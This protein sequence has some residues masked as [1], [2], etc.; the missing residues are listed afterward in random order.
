MDGH[1][2]RQTLALLNSPLMLDRRRRTPLKW[3]SESCRIRAAAFSLKSSSVCQHLFR[4]QPARIRSAVVRGP[5]T[6]PGSLADRVSVSMS[7]HVGATTTRQVSTASR[8]Q[9][10]ASPSA[11]AATKTTLQKSPPRG[12]LAICVQR[13]PIVLSRSNWRAVVKVRRAAHYT[14]APNWPSSVRTIPLLITG[15]C[16]KNAALRE[17]GF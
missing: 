17:R 1:S 13:R 3:H 14:L 12:T 9:T 16:S 8:R 11:A 5:H 10:H 2:E 7:R 6:G 15:S 4:N